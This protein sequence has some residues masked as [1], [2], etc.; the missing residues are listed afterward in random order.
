[1][2]KKALV[3]WLGG[4]DDGKYAIVDCTWIKN[5]DPDKWKSTST[6]E[7]GESEVVEWRL[8]RKP[9]SGFYQCFDAKIICV[10]SKY[11][12]QIPINSCCMRPL[13]VLA[14]NHHSTLIFYFY[15]QVMKVSWNCYCKF[16]G[17]NFLMQ[18]VCCVLCFCGT[19]PDYSRFGAWIVLRKLPLL[20]YLL[21]SVDFTSHCSLALHLKS[22]HPVPLLFYLSSLTLISLTCCRQELSDFRLGNSRAEW[23]IRHLTHVNSLTLN[24]YVANPQNVIGHMR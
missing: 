2:P 7:R 6:P 24:S 3:K 9:A 11:N 19:T 21:E 13:W 17:R 4:E 15:C 16:C 8:G 12:V 10:S 22:I 18:F 20:P 5:F 23:G 1:M 14:R